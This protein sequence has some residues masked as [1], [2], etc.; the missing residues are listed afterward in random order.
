[1][2]S[3]PF[4]EARKI[5]E[6]SP[7]KKDFIFETGY[8][9]S[10][11]P[12]IGTFAEVVR[13]TM[14]INALKYLKPDVK[15]RLITFSDDMDGLRKIPD[16]IPDKN[17]F[18]KHIGKPLTSIPDPFCEYE[19]YGEYMN[20]QL[21]KFLDLFDFEYEFKSSTICYKSGFFNDKLLLVLENYDKIMEIILP[22]IGEERRKTYSPFL[23]ICKETGVVLQVP[24][25]I[26]KDDK[27]ITYMD[28]NNKLITNPILD[29][30]CKLQWK[31]DWGM[32][33]AAI[34]VDYE[35][36]GKDLT[37]SAKISKK[38]C[39]VLGGKT[40]LLF[41]YELFLDEKGQKISKSK[42][43]GLSIKE[44]LLYAPRESLS[45]YMFQN[46]QRA[47]KLYFESIPKSVDEYISSVEKYDG[48]KDNPVWHVHAGNVPKFENQNINF[49]LLLNLV[50]VC[51]PENKNVLLGFIKKNKQYISIENNK[52][53]T[54]ML[55]YAISYYNDF[56]KINKK[57]KTPN[58]YEKVV[59][60][61]FKNALLQLND[62]ATS[63]DIQGVVFDIGRK[64]YKKIG[65][66][67]ELLYK[68]LF[69]QER[70][71]KIG[72]FFYLYGKKKSIELIENKINNSEN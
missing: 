49:S 43:N 12:H 15:T 17:N 16:N 35:M 67:F 63:D 39:S 26:N 41:V 50:S 29:G 13:T 10:G 32:R 42:G 34:G 47:K 28:C 36:H 69:G 7:G 20:A 3:W 21:L 33:W 64:N 37:P 61:G 53:I 4:V 23:P 44:W 38:I 55:S 65:E 68:V 70:G 27:T 57:Y 8:G 1:M 25:N 24:V 19:S 56:I 22:N 14:V 46:P 48:C 72:T 60:I 9:P 30:K 6:Q 5:L 66:W 51:N 54:Q 18:E 11:L 71:P 45:F 2:K 31:V 58:E 59:L 40:P 52:L 62:E